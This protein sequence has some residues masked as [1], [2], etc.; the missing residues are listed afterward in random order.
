MLQERAVPELPAGKGHVL[1]VDDQDMVRDIGKLLL[2]ELGY[3]VSLAA[4]GREALALYRSCWQDIDLV[5]IDM[6]MPNMGGTECI[7]AMHGENPALRAVLSSGYSRE[8]LND[9][10]DA[11]Q[12]AGFLQKPFRLQEL[13]TLLCGLLDQRG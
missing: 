12:V 3:R 8:L 7:R 9:S 5:I 13:S 1:L 2:Q 10:I 4:D 11:Q 6:V